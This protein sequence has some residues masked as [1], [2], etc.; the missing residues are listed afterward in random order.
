[1]HQYGNTSVVKCTVA[2]I[3]LVPLDSL[4]SLSGQSN[5]KKTIVESY[6]ERVIYK[7]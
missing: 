3:C 6:G 7:E 2:S 4:K 5:S 1:M